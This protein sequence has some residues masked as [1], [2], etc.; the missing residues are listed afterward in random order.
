MTNRP[1]RNCFLVVIG[2]LLFTLGSLQAQAQSACTG[3]STVACKGKD[4]CS[5]V[6]GYTTKSGT[7]V[8]SYCRLKPG[9]KSAA[10]RTERK[11]TEKT[12][13]GKSTSASVTETAT[14]RTTGEKPKNKMT[15]T[16]GKEDEV[17][18]PAKKS[19]SEKSPKDVNQKS[20]K[21]TKSKKSKKQEKSKKNEGQKKQK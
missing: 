4:A 10:D 16:A 1:I 13:A 9:R 6:K 15:K 19:S 3:L 5:W 17:K 7:T 18:T 20:T 2:S 14:E 12:K 8:K 21:S 11:A